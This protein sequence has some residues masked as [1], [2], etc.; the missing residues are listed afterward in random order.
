MLYKLELEDLKTS[1]ALYNL[2][3]QTKP[4]NVIVLFRVILFVSYNKFGYPVC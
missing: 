2:I 3:S 1:A 4:G